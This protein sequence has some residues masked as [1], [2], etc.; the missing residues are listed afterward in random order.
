MQHSRENVILVSD[1]PYSY[2]DK[3]KASKYARKVVAPKRC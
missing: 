1:V 3:K 2:Q